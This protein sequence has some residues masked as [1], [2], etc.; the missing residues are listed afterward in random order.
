MNNWHVLEKCKKTCQGADRVVGGSST[1][2]AYH[3]FRT[4]PNSP[5]NLATD[6]LGYAQRLE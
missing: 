2:I 4:A 5:I 6:D 1:G 3:A